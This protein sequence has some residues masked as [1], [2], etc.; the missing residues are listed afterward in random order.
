[1]LSLHLE[2]R[3]RIIQAEESAPGKAR[4]Q[5]KRKHTLSQMSGLF[6]WYEESLLLWG[7]HLSLEF[8]AQVLLRI[9]MECQPSEKMRFDP[10]PNV[11]A[12]SK[13]N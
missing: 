1:M 9:A 12:P 3:E 10:Q 4:R 8:L 5:D 11:H 2:T 13:T 7:C 6:L